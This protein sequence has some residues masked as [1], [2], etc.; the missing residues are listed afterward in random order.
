MTRVRWMALAV[1]VLVVSGLSGCRVPSPTVARRLVFTPVDTFLHAGAARVDITPPIHLALFGHG[2]E[3]RIATGVRLRLRCSAFV[4]ARAGE[5]VALVPC[6]LQSPSLA[7]HRAVAARLDAFGVPIAPERLLLMATHTHGAPAHYFESPRYSGPFSSSAPGHDPKVLAFLAERIAGAVAEA[8]A[9]LA[10]ACAG[11]NH[12]DVKRLTFN[13]A[14][15]PFQANRP[16]DGEESAFI[17]HTRDVVAA[18]RAGD[19]LDPTVEDPRESAVDTSMFALRI[20]RRKPNMMWCDGSDVLGALAVFG[21]HPTG[22][23]NTNQLYH[24]DIF[25]FATRIAEGCLANAKPKVA[26]AT[27]HPAPSYPPT[28]ELVP[29]ENVHRECEEKPRDEARAPIVGLAN[30]I[31]GDVSPR[32]NTQTFDQAR[33]LGRRL[34]RAITNAVERVSTSSGDVPLQVKYWELWFPEGRY[35]KA[36]EEPDAKLC[37]KPELGMAS[38]GGARDGPTRLRVIPEAN[39]GYRLGEGA[40]SRLCHGEKLPLRASISSARGHEFPAIGPMALLRIGDGFVV[41]TPGEVTTMTGLRI[42]R[43]VEKHVGL[44]AQSNR[45]AVVGLTNAYLQY[46][47][48]KE[49]YGFQLYEGASTL[50]GPN[51]SAFLV[52]HAACLGDALVGRTPNEC[53]EQAPFDTHLSFGSYPDPIVDRLP[54][55]PDDF[56]PTALS[57]LSLRALEGASNGTSQRP[58]APLGWETFIE[59]LPP[60]FVGDRTKF[61]VVVLDEH[62]NV[63]DDDSGASIEVRETDDGKQW[64]I[65][66]FPDISDQGDP[67]TPSRTCDARCGGRYRLA[68]RG[69]IS[70][71]SNLVTVSCVCSPGGSP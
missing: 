2:P 20:D 31:E 63:V 23:E 64:R 5:I 55:E 24:G 10:P 28:S 52:R 8:Y 50:Y 21:M 13:R 71:E 34:G 48:T 11:W 9:S 7:L 14:F 37:A 4:L 45:V 32:I 49:E 3:S 69:R 54:R 6:D 68:V 70:L 53:P 43:A 26:E 12:E 16:T 47:A 38:G 1:L 35:R 36:T 40:A 58:G 39:A 62:G 18:G 33:Q 29:T 27:T 67:G 19:P 30:G 57:G 59:D 60:T 51:S 25:G 17:S 56:H 44:A 46:F 61:H 66:W 15:V 22:V 65:R 41:T 42:R